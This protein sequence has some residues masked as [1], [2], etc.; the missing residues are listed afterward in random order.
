MDAQDQNNYEG[1]KSIEPWEF[2]AAPDNLPLGLDLPAEPP[3]DKVSDPEEDTD[4]RQAQPEPNDVELVSKE[5]PE[6]SEA[7]RRT[8]EVE[9]QVIDDAA[10]DTEEIE[11]PLAAYSKIIDD[12][13]TTVELDGKF[14]VFLFFFCLIYFNF[15]FFDLFEPCM[16]RFIS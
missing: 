6:I 2:T 16:Y 8:S 4:F 1:F 10:E 14:G 7:E 9:P 15:F 11:Q 5:K 12:D 13:F 3:P